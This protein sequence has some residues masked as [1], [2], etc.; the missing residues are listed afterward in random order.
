MAKA[1]YALRI[2]SY[3]LALAVFITIGVFLL[4]IRERGANFTY[5]KTVGPKRIYTSVVRQS[6]ILDM[7]VCHCAPDRDIRL[8][9]LEGFETAASNLRSEWSWSSPR[10]CRYSRQHLARSEPVHVSASSK[11]LG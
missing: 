6:G 10:H 7:G 5:D 4:A 8:P 1:K 11:S 2:V 3:A 9:L